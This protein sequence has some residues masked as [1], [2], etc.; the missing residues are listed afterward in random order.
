MSIEEQIRDF[1][2]KV[3]IEANCKIDEMN[4]DGT[5]L[6][7]GLY[8]DGIRLG[9]YDT[10]EVHLKKVKEIDIPSANT[11]LEVN[12]GE[13]I[14][15]DT[16]A[17]DSTVLMMSFITFKRKIRKLNTYDVAQLTFKNG[18]E[19]GIL[20]DTKKHACKTILAFKKAHEGV[21]HKLIHV[22]KF[23]E[24]EVSELDM[25]TSPIDDEVLVSAS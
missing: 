16:N 3:S 10:I 17:M 18:D 25:M 2:R 19:Y 23:S 5:C 13:H 20:C 4:V 11:N 14:W 24:A 21:K 7:K 22:D 9:E 1:F 15:L 6:D 8:L 12:V